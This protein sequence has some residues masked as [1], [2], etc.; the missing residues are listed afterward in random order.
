[1]RNVAREAVECQLRQHLSTMVTVTN[2]ARRKTRSELPHLKEKALPYQR[3]L[4]ELN[5]G[6]TQRMANLAGTTQLCRSSMK[7]IVWLA[8][9]KSIQIEFAKTRHA[10]H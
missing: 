4:Q 6:L 2:V 10:M 9:R 5:A 1:M 8:S 7:D 3:I